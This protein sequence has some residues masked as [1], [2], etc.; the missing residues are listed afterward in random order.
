MDRL[1]KWFMGFWGLMLLG[2]IISYL[3]PDL[4]DA[5]ARATPPPPVSIEIDTAAAVREMTEVQIASLQERVRRLPASEVEANRSAY[6]QL[7][8]LVPDVPRYRERFEHYDSL[9]RA[10]VGAQNRRLARFGPMPQPSAWDGT[11]TVVRDY[12]RRVAN[13][14]GSIDLDVCTGVY[15]VDEGWLIGCDYRGKNGFGALIRTSNWFI[16]RFG[17]V[18]DMKDASAYK[19]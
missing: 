18:I 5:P 7:M 9:A 16:I 1:Y 17:Q 8:E 19:R 13:D 3:D 6:R 12:L 11:Y 10:E 15:Q 2:F 14:P 4:P